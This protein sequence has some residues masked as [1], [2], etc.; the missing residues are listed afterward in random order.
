MTSAEIRKAFIDFFV[1]KHGHTFVPSSPVV[2]LNVADIG[3]GAEFRV[4]DNLA[5]RAAYELPLTDA[6]N[7]LYGWRVTVSAV[8]SF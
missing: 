2:S 3:C 1:S 8:Y 6:D 5:L 4:V 7:D